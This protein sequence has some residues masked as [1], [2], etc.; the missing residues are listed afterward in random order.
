M[1]DTYIHSCQVP[2]CKTQL[3]EKEKLTRTECE[4]IF[5]EKAAEKETAEV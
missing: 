5:A 1:K 3:I 2:D 4:A